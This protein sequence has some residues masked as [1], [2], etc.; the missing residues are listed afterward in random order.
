MTIITTQVGD[1]DG[2]TCWTLVTP[3]AK[4]AL[5]FLEREYHEGSSLAIT[6]LFDAEDGYKTLRWLADYQ[7]DPFVPE[8][9]YISSHM[10]LSVLDLVPPS[11][12]K[13]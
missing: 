6:V 7:G 4:R 9:R 3:I 12:V 5:E 1:I 13:L 2:Q 10:P 8:E 11:R